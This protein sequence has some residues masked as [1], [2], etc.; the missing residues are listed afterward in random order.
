MKSGLLAGAM[1]RE[2]VAD[3]HPEDWRR[4]SPFFQ[5]PALTRNLALVELLRTI[6]ARHGAARGKWPLPGLCVIPP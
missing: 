5:E 2:R 4:R 1:S 6:G 3:L